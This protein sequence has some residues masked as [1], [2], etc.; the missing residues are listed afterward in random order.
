MKRFPFNILFICIFLPPVCYILTLQI[1]EGYFQQRE[2]SRLNQIIVQNLD[3]LKEG[4]Y[5]I[6]EEI[7]RNILHYL[8]GSL[9]YRLGL[10]TQIIV[11]TRDD[12]ILYPAES[13][14]DLTESGSEG[15][16]SELPLNS[17]NYTEVAAENYEILNEGLVLV[18]NVQI[19][20]NT[21]LANSILILYIFLFVFILNRFIQ[22]R[23]KDSER[24]E[25]EQRDLIDTLSARLSHADSELSVVKIQETEYLNKISA[26]K[27]EKSNQSQDID[28]LLEEMEKME[29][30]LQ[31]Q[32]NLKEEKELEIMQLKEDLERLK[33]KRHK[34][35]KKKKLEATGKRFKVLYKNLAFTE[36]AIEGFLALS[37]DVQLKAEEI[38]H[39][40]N[41][42]TS[43][44]SVKRKVF[45]KGGKMNIL[46]VD[47]SYSGRVYYQ[48]DSLPKTRVLAIGTKNS[49]DQD[50][51]FLEKVK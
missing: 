44:V 4:R 41:D 33:E 6:K 19:K 28:G 22:K 29:A 40:L 21:W 11:K 38:I 9:K 39:K 34:P 8:S 50:L 12:R 18:I 30:G 5:S 46:E 17:L 24:Q 35:K 13:K 48:K 27:K 3:A 37:D 45:G 49:Q 14:R 20:H 16:F 7:R 26:L 10:R 25:A 31:G 1:L 42:D 36:R 15:D 43:K 47:F 32:A 51:A 2:T 23:I